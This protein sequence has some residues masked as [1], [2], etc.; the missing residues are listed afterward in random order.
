[1]PIQLYPTSPSALSDGTY[2]DIVVSASGTVME[3]VPLTSW[4][5]N[6]QE[7]LE[8]A[9]ENRTSDPGSP[10]SGQIW[11]RTDL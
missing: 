3:F 1:M 5:G 7:A 8:L 10:V 11:L 2:G 6:Q 4:D 9:V